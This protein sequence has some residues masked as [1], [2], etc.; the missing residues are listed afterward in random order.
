[1]LRTLPRDARVAGR[2]SRGSRAA[3]AAAR[4]AGRVL[5]TLPRD[6]RVAG[7]VLR[8]L[9]R[10]VRGAGC[11]VGTLPRDVRGGGA[12]EAR[13]PIRSRGPRAKWLGTLGRFECAKFRGG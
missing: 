6:V 3:H 1:M 4:G 11:V 10:D 12:G 7:R 13:T 2:E 5:R 9:P 8:T